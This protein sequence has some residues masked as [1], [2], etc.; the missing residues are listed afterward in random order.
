MQQNRTAILNILL[1]SIIFFLLSPVATAQLSLNNL[2]LT[3]K[4]KTPDSEILD[5][6]EKY[7]DTEALFI[8]DNRD[9]ILKRIHKSDNYKVKVDYT[10]ILANVCWYTY[11]KEECKTFILQSDSILKNNNDYFKGLSNHFRIKGLYANILKDKDAF[12]LMLDTAP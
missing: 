4:N 6:L 1:L 2:K 11:K 3:L 10:N 5:S 8:Y 7:V 12:K 9:F